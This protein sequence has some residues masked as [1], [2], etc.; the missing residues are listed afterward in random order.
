MLRSLVRFLPCALLLLFIA[1]VQADSIGMNFT[2]TR[3]GGG[4]YPILPHE[5]AGLVP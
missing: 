1:P 4:P 2:A 5:S 3:F